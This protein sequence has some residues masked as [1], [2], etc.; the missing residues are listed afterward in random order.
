MVPKMLSLYPISLSLLALQAAAQNCST[1]SSSG[2]I[3]QKFTIS[4]AG[5]NASF[6]NYGARL[7]NLFVNDKN[8]NPQDVALGYDTPTQYINDTNTVHS[9]YGAVVGRYANR[10]KNGT[11]TVDGTTSHIPENEN[12]GTDTLQYVFPSL[13]HDLFKEQRLITASTLQWRYNR[14]RP[15]QLDRRLR[16]RIQHNLLLARPRLRRLPRH[17]HHLRNLLRL[18][19]LDRSNMDESPSI[20]PPRRTDPNHARKPRLLEPRRLHQPS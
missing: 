15:T 7:T 18:F 12:N 13:S 6:I 1:S 8:G 10:I 2:F 9:Y 20:D 4:A 19:L 3:N 17:R 11:F 14:L 16:E 5:I